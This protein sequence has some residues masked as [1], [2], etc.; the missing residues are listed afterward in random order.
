MYFASRGDSRDVGKMFG[1]CVCWVDGWMWK[2]G[3]VPGD[4]G[5]GYLVGGCVGEGI[6]HKR[7]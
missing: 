2:G 1:V 5:Y 4:G 3:C 7:F 6:I